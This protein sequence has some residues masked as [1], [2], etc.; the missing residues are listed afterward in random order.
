MTIF[1]GQVA[2]APGSTNTVGLFASRAGLAPTEGDTFTA[3]DGARGTWVY[4]G[5]SWRPKIG[6]IIGTEPTI[7]GFVTEDNWSTSTI[8]KSGGVVTMTGP[9]NGSAAANVIYKTIPVPTAFGLTAHMELLSNHGNVSVLSGAGL[10]M[11]EDATGKLAV[12]HLTSYN[13]Q[14]F[15]T[16]A[17]YASSGSISGLEKLGMIQGASCWLRVR[18]ASTTLYFEAGTAL[19]TLST[20]TLTSYFTTAPDQYGLMNKGDGATQVGAII[21]S[22]EES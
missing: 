7:T 1:V 3:T 13:N 8:A 2:S 21:R 15:V 19:A 17:Y 18:R 5:G 20:A 11:R 16:I 14:T 9:N 4:T 6:D 12:W 22:L 10:A